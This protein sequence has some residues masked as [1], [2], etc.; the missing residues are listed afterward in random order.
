MNRQMSG[1]VVDRILG[2]LGERGADVVELLQR[3]RDPAYEA[4]WRQD[5]DARLYRAFARRLIGRGH[6]ARAY[7]LVQDGLAQHPQHLELRYWAALALARGGGARKA[8]EYVNDLLARPGLDDRLR[9]EA[10]S[11]RGR[12]K[13][14]AYER[15]SDP[16]LKQE[17]ARESATFYESAYAVP[18]A[19]S[20][21]GVNAA[22]MWLLAGQE[23]KARELAP[24]VV[25]QAAEEHRDP[26]RAGDYW[27]AATL[28][29]ANVVLGRLGVAVGWYRQA[30]EQA[31]GRTGD[32][33]S[34]RRQVRLLAE[35]VSGLEEILSALDFGRVV[36]FAGHMID[37]PSRAREGLAARFPPGEALERA[38]AQAISDRLEQ[39]DA[40]IGYAS[41]A[42]GSDVL[43]GEAL[44][45]RASRRHV[46]YHVV[47]PFAL[48]D[49]YFT[50]VD[51]G[52][53]AMRSWRARSDALR[54]R[55][56][57]VHSATP[58]HFRGDTVLFEWVNTVTQ[59]LALL[60]AARLGVEP[61]ALVVVDREG[62]SGAP[63]PVGGTAY[64]AE[65]WKEG[66]RE[67]QEIDL[68][69]LRRAAVFRVS[70][71]PDASLEDG[72]PVRPSAVSA[73]AA[74]AVDTP[75]T[76]QRGPVPREVKAMLFADVKNY[77]RLDDE[78]TPL[79]VAT[80]LGEV[81]RVIDGLPRPPAFRN[82]WGD[83]LYLVFDR[84]VD[85]AEFAMRL[86]ERTPEVDW[87]GLGLPGD[88]TFR[89]GIHAGPVYRQRDEIIERENFFGGHVT[90]AARIEPVT[91]PG[92]AF[93]SEQFAAALTAEPGHD[94]VCE[95]VGT[96]WLAK[97]S[98]RST[99]YRL[100]RR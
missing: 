45:A 99:L 48:D 42:C 82:T 21:P 12:L 53:E 79:F 73:P 6:P 78:R 36:V 14:D 28:G 3:Y 5:P 56:S 1:D 92:A 30:V 37:H 24:R 46:E 93:A 22:T 23:D 95:F 69:V 31:R 20:F 34:M 16:V 77:S 2:E 85:C 60:H 91:V 84:V 86:L 90:R 88:T 50:S 33:S 52:I 68:A 35:V 96:E 47:L 11:L 9:A 63:A 62:L 80:L 26:A 13:K 70:T 57:G 25:E 55:A 10:L 59:G 51:F 94:F 61:C 76:V 72:E 44:L 29:E 39:L 66:G 49:F 32:L 27:S 58:E 87:A 38:V 40:T 100:A 41:V 4:A 7:E 75:A 67:L 19:D 83:G 65:R 8:E 81:R 97:A 71:G 15:A 17:L 43:F 64:F 18:G 74:P 89:I 98:G 54:G